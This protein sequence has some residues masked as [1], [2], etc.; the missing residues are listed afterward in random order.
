MMHTHRARRRTTAT[1]LTGALAIAPLVWA[2][3]ALAANEQITPIAQIQGTGSATPLAGKSVT[4]RGVVT[5]AYP[6]GGFRGFVIQTPGTGETVPEASHAVFVYANSTNLPT[7]GQYVEVTGTAGEYNGLTQLSQPTWTALDDDVEAPT[8][9]DIAWPETNDEREQLESMLYQPSSYDF[10]VSNTYS[11]NQYGEVGLAFGD[12]PLRQP[13]DV[14]RPGSDKAAAIQAENIAKSVVLDDGA[15]TNFFSTKAAT[16]PYI[17]LDEP[18]RVGA[19]VVFDEPVVVDYRNNL[20]KLN[21]TAQA[22]P[23]EEPASAKN[24]RTAGP[25]AK[26]LGDADLTVASFNVLNYFTT[27]GEDWAAQG[28]TCTAYSDRAGTKITVKSCSNNGPRGAWNDQSLTRQQDKIVAAINTLDSAVVGLLEIENSAALGEEPDEATATL[29]AALNAAAGEERWDYIRSSTD[30]PPVNQQ[31]A[32]TNAVIYQPALVSPLGD[33][34][35]LGDQSGDGQPFSNAREPLG[36]A[37]TPTDDGDPF[38]FVVNH[39][40]SKGSA[41]PLPGDTDQGDGQ[42]SSNASRVAQATALRDWVESTITSLSADTEQDITDV[43]LTGDFNSYTQ[44]DPMQVFYEAGYTNSTP[45]LNDGEY[46]YSFSGL[47]GSLDHVLFNESFAD[48]ITGADIWNINSG[49]SIALEYSRYNYHGTVF[50][51]PDAYRSSDHDPVIIG[52]KNSRGGS[53]QKSVDINLLDIND[54]HGRIDNNTVK[55][56]GTVEAARAEYPDSTLFLS[57]GDNIGASVFASAVQDDKPTLDVLNALELATSAVGNHEFDVSYEHLTTTVEDWS[58]FDY[59]GAN[60]YTAGTTEPALKEYAVFDV[61]GVS[62]GVIGAITEETP[63]LVTPGGIEAIEFGDPVEAVN[64]VAEQLT[65]GDDSNGEADVLVAL[66]HEGAGAGTPDGSDLPEEIA[67]GGVFADI[68]TN[69]S[70]EVA[71]IFTG[72]TH[73]QYAWLGDNGDKAQRPIIQT[74][75]YGEHIGQAVLTV[76]T[77]T[78]EV[79]EAT[80]KNIA[81]STVAD[82][83]LI[84]AYPRVAEVSSIV[85]Q[86]LEYAKEVGSQPVG[87][88]TADITTAYT[89]GEY[90]DGVYTGGSRDDRASASTLGTVV[91]NSLRDSL[92]TPER[93]GADFGVVNPGGLRA[94]LLYGDDGV[95]TYAE[96]NAVLPFVNNLWTT[97]FTGAQVKTMLE[98][99]WQRTSA[100]DVPSRPYLQ[101]GLSDNVTYTFDASRDEGDRITSIRINDEELDPAR[102][103]VVGTF[104]FLAQGG[105]NFHV[106][107]EG[108]DTRDS[109]LIDREAWIAYLEDNKEL[110]PSFARQGVSVS[111]L[112]GELTP[113]E[114]VT[115]TLSRLNMTSLGSPVNTTLAVTFDGGSL[116]EPVTAGDVDVTTDGQGTANVTLEVPD[117]AAGATV[118]RFVADPSGT[119]VTLPVTVAEGTAPEPEFSTRTTFTAGTSIAGADTKIKVKV[120]ATAPK[121]SKGSSKKPGKPFGT[122]TF[123]EGDTKL[124]TARVKNGKVTTSIVLDAGRHA[125]TAT[126]TPDDTERYGEST[127][128][129]VKIKT[130]KAR[131]DV[132]TK[133]DTTRVTLPDTATVSIKVIAKKQA[134]AP[135]GA[136]MIYSGRDQIAEGVLVPGKKSTS[137]VDIELVDLPAGTYRDLVAVYP[138]NDNTS[139]ST[140]TIRT[141]TVRSAR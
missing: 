131:S 98:Q 135:E 30:L 134:A 122:V 109:G 68:A 38:F 9:L 74:G 79:T 52:L 61:S 60:V 102:E 72:H 100:G 114:T 56:A 51:A 54:F 4:T 71:A 43:A 50:Y 130:S 115:T 6:T 31:D 3:T 64:R 99:Q 15:T 97:T 105:D 40:K 126:F 17:S 139:R 37:F 41:G 70:P 59:L 83:E 42:G 33:S 140:E 133:L 116:N 112:P 27:T 62:V 82:N 121:G 89:D 138:G 58:D 128:K 124:G 63:S 88:V 36:Q 13:T 91:A 53:D 48:R 73:K 16:P 19:P 94:D 69:T 106:F 108:Q 141:L 35:A 103:Y 21:P 22:L 23:G 81:R 11:T 77:T 78:G 119:T 137:T 39:F 1:L 87:S 86:A 96:A 123:M 120:T 8:P 129:V 49:E 18:F 110:S 55:F 93:G 67:A 44:E 85:T 118:M 7:L 136:V 101:L 92:S 90:V 32:I 65:D 117:A 84:A 20:W 12:T 57:A 14:A 45:E 29:V 5:A 28:N 10:T 76:D 75:S 95:I 113:G 24:T 47:A 80:A 2:P 66:Y 26:S 132:Q 107:T 125:V 25:D 104:S 127:S 34:R 46:S 111:S